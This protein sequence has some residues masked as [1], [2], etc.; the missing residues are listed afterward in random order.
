MIN[1][2]LNR[3]TLSMRAGYTLDQ[4]ISAVGEKS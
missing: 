4:M 1:L 3:K 2:V